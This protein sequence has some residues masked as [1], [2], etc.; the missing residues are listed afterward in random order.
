MTS[1]GHVIVKEN[2]KQ[3]LLWENWVMPGKRVFKIPEKSKWDFNSF[4]ISQMWPKKKKKERERESEEDSA[5]ITM[6]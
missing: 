5:F 3:N 1:E 2:N 6:F 4:N